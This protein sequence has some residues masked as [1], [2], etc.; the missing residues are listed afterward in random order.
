MSE[1]SFVVAE[2]Q[3][4]TVRLDPNSL[5]GRDMAGVPVLYMP[6]KLQLLPGGQKRDVEYTLLRLAGTLQNQPLGE[7][8]RFEVTPLAAGPNSTPFDRPQD[9][10]VTL[11][12]HQ[13]SDLKTHARGATRVSRSCS[14]ALSGIQLLKGSTLSP[15]LGIST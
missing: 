10:F 4:A 1:V 9:A 11:D 15:R 2:H 13:V 6:L 12:R 14:P 3:V 8:A 5:Q 7:F